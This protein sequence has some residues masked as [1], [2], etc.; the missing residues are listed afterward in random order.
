MEA[1]VGAASFSSVDQTIPLDRVV[2]LSTNA[3][4]SSL[5]VPS[6]LGDIIFD[7]VGT[8]GNAQVDTSGFLLPNRTLIYADGTNDVK[9]G[10]SLRSATVGTTTM[11]WK[12]ASQSYDWGPDRRCHQRG[13]QRYHLYLS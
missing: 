2:K 4:Q 13:I 3:N 6:S 7:V 9:S 11:S 1:T 5:S 12:G 10:S 8:N